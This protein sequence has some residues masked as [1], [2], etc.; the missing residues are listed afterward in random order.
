MTRSLVT[1]IKTPQSN[2]SF[3][4]SSDFFVRFHGFDCKLNLNSYKM[5]YNEVSKA[6]LFNKHIDIM[7][8]F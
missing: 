8:Y 6:I 1:I 2:H 3:R 4:A 5:L 7:T